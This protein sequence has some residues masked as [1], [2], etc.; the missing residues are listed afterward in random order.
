VHDN[1]RPEL[2]E[3]LVD[4]RGVGDRSFDDIEPIIL[5]QSV[6]PPAREV[7][8]HQHRVP[9]IEQPVGEM[10][11]DEAGAAREQDLGHAP[12]SSGVVVIDVPR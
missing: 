9:A 5:G 10:R 7:V 1:V 8:D 2:L 6:A 4:E 12:S 3:G 11:G